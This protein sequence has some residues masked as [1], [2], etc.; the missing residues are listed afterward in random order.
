MQNTT[1]YVY[2]RWDGV[3]SKEF[4]N[5]VLETIDW[6]NSIAAGVDSETPS[7][8]NKQR[9]TD[10][11][12]QENLNPIGCV[13]KSYIEAAN[14]QAGWNYDLSVYEKVQLSRY[15]GEDKGHYAWHV[16][17][18]PPREGMQRKLSCVILLNDPSEFE[19]GELQFG[20]I[21]DENMLT[22]QGSIIVCPSFVVH[23]VT[24]VTQ[25]VRYTAVAWANG[26]AFR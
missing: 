12:W 20:P 14:Q 21:G 23:R 9:R 8:D 7:I 26:P 11:I 17:I 18:A 10:I 5:S 19:G 3:L 2:W 22:M 6:D 25:G 24:P 4:C 1:E 16:D 13:A 15:K